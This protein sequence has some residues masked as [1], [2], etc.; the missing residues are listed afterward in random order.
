MQHASALPLPSASEQTPNPG[1]ITAMM[2]PRQQHRRAEDK[3]FNLLPGLKVYQAGLNT[4]WQALV[5]LGVLCAGVWWVA[6]TSNDI[7]TLK[8]YGKADYVDIQELKQQNMVLQTEVQQ[9]LTAQ[10]VT[11]LIPPILHNDTEQVP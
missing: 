2:P 9:L 8:R 6:S 1:D 10:H 4:L 7:S 5:I 3:G 11:P